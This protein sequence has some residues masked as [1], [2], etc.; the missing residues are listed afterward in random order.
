M[1]YLNP[2]DVFIYGGAYGNIPNSIGAF[3]AKVDPDTLEPIWYRQLIDTTANG[4]WNYP[5]VVGLLN[6]G[7]LYVIFG[8]RL[9]KIDPRDGSAVVKELPTDPVVGPENTSYN[10]FDGLPDGTL[11]AK[12]VYRSPLCENLQGPDALFKCP[13][14][15]QVPSS[16]LISIDPHTLQVLDQITL[17]EPVG[18]RPTTTRFRGDDYVYLATPTTAIRY[19]VQNG[20]FTKDEFWTPGNF[21]LPHQTL[22]S[23]V[24]IMNDWFVVQSNGNPATEPLSVI[25][26]NQADAAQQFSVQPFKDFP[27]VQPVTPFF[28]LGIQSWAPMSVSVDPDRNLIYTADSYPGVI[29]ALELAPDGLRTVWTAQQRTTEFLALIGPRGRRVVLGTDF[30][31]QAPYVNTTDFVVWRDALTGHELARTAE[32]LPAMTVGTMIQPYYFGEVFYMGL[33]GDLFELTVRPGGR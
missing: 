31:G 27:V 22:G 12:T 9:A 25:A 4:E 30:P 7:F 6:D 13:T 16:I 29:G 24:A 1:V 15:T 33:D 17:P 23:A 18:G 20:K 28:P 10:G 2:N 3:V 14:A 26:I 11:I 19:L 8:Y 32:A 5:G 21:Y